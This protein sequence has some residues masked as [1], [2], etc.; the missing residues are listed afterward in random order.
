A[1]RYPV[2]AAA[3]RCIW[4]ANTGASW[5]PWAYRDRPGREVRCV[6]CSAWLAP[7]G[8]LFRLGRRGACSGTARAGEDFVVGH[9]AAPVLAGI[10]LAGGADDA[11]DIGLE[12]GDRTA[13]PGAPGAGEQAAV[14]I[15]QSHVFLIET[16]RAAP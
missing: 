16:H 7:E 9:E 15:R 3:P 4:D 5:C 12:G 10:E 1:A 8:C 2:R 6:G 14:E 13:V 11:A